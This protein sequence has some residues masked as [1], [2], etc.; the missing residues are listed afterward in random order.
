MD[1]QSNNFIALAE[2]AIEQGTIPQ[3][4]SQGTRMAN[5]RRMVAMSAGSE[6]GE[7]IRQQAAYAK[8][9]ALQHLADLLEE[10][11]ERL[12]ENGFTVLWAETAEEARQHVL[13]IAQRHHI[14]RVAKSKSM[15]TE[16]IALNDALIEAQIE[17]VETDLGEYLLQINNEAPSHIVIPVIHKSKAEVRALM[18]D[19]MGMP[20][21]EDASEMVAFARQRMRQTFLE[22]E[23]GITGGNF[24]IAETGSLCLATNEGN[25]RMV[26]TLPRVQVSLI[27]IEKIVA[28]VEDYAT[29][30]QVL[31]RS[32]T[33]QNLTVYTNILNGRSVDG[34]AEHQYLIFVDNGRSRIYADSR[35]TES[36]ACLRCGACLNTCPV[37]RSTG[38]H[39]YG[40][41][42]GGP[43]GAVVSPLLK[44][45][46]QTTPLPN[47][48]S[49]CGSCK[50]VCPVDIDIPRMLLDL[51]HDIITQN[52][53]EFLISASMKVWEQVNRSPQLFE[54]GG[55]M[56]QLGLQMGADEWVPNPLG[57]WKAYR[58]FPGFAPQ[59][60]RAQWRKHQKEKKHEQQ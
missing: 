5:G 21:I 47:A 53:G 59:S 18:Q 31:P 10:A 60:F 34:G 28:T 11:E 16:E 29:L 3:A 30:A 56:A 15:V 39:A 55:K 14:T 23:M 44:G 2:I 51:R 40:W 48:S 12:T 36:L 52:H 38:G 57:D 20:Y 13:A 45:L 32:G 4:V 6:H 27:G 24:V 8:R 41:V 35:Y 46:D 37:Y 42:Y 50:E 19:K 43:I 49:L 54:L 9:Y 1:V 58:D 26:T 25:G 17:V 7:A 22:A 33:G